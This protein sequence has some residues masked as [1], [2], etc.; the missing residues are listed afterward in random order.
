MRIWE[1][2][3]LTTAAILFDSLEKWVLVSATDI[4]KIELKTLDSENNESSM[5]RQTLRYIYFLG[6]WSYQSFGCQEL[7]HATSS[8]WLQPL[9]KDS[10]NLEVI[11]Q[12]KF[13]IPF[14][15]FRPCNREGTVTV[16]HG[17]R[18]REKSSVILISNYVQYIFTW[19][20]TFALSLRW[21]GNIE[22]SANYRPE[23]LYQL[24]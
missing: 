13:S 17:Y 24:L 19:S 5:E 4:A 9:E 11:L 10:C 18:L 23:S 21:R 16:S 1:W 15:L 8:N 12:D 20:P 2:L 7:D 14:L 6:F 3:C 22:N